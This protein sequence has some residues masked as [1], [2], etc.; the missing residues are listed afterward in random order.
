MFLLRKTVRNPLNPHKIKLRID[1]PYDLAVPLLRI[2]LKELK[3]TSRR[4]ISSALFVT[5]L[6]TI[7]KMFI[8]GLIVRENVA[9]VFH[10]ILLGFKN[11]GNPEIYD[12]MDEHFRHCTKQNKSQKDRYCMILLI[13]ADNRLAGARTV[14]KGKWEVAV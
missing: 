2:Y 5:V 6:F 3:S 9:Y 12:N 7:A 11:E 14:W 10:G 8:T 1:L 13:E 4:Y